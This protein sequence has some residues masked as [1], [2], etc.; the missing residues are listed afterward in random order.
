M[1][2]PTPLQLSPL[3]PSSTSQCTDTPH[4]LLGNPS[5][6]PL[7]PWSRPIPWPGTLGQP[8]LCPAQLCRPQIA[9]S[10]EPEPAGLGDWCSGIPGALAQPP[11]P[12]ALSLQEEGIVN[13]NKLGECVTA[14]TH[15]GDTEE[16]ALEWLGLWGL[17]PWPGAAV[18]S[19]PHQPQSGAQISGGCLVCLVHPPV[20]PQHARPRACVPPFQCPRPSCRVAGLMRKLGTPCTTVCSVNSAVR[21]PRAGDASCCGERS[22]REAS[23]SP[24]SHTGRAGHLPQPG[25]R[26]HAAAVCSSRM[27]PRRAFARGSPWGPPHSS[28]RLGNCREKAGQRRALGFLP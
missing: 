1:H 19:G 6:S 11:C 14:E 5:P 16:T 22:L 2:T 8:H 3:T 25:H 23:L 17:L 4:T 9:E 21:G 28:R 15:G 18:G 7:A 12:P 27:V 10:R 26:A 24:G 13:C 20:W